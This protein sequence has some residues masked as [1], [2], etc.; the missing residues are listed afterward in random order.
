MKPMTVTCTDTP[1][2]EHLLYK[3]LT[4]SAEG[5]SSREG[6][7]VR[8]WCRACHLH[9]QQQSSAPGKE[10]IRCRTRCVCSCPLNGSVP[11]C[12]ITTTCTAH[13][14]PLTRACC[15]SRIFALRRRVLGV[16]ALK[17][18]LHAEVA[19]VLCHYKASPITGDDAEGRH[20]IPV[21]ILKARLGGADLYEA[22]TDEA[23]VAHSQLPLAL[24][25]HAHGLPPGQRVRQLG[26]GR[27]VAVL[28]AAT[29]N[30]SQEYC[31]TL[32]TWNHKYTTI[33]QMAA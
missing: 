23:G 18:R 22:P 3:D 13:S 17:H 1:S 8:C 26:Q 14:G 11:T 10:P 15:G 16:K 6:R 30:H 19:P 4:C 20:Q 28:P 29:T 7:Q 12:T 21:L 33:G 31:G 32:Q 2:P 27:W 24:C 9:S 5:S 25:Q